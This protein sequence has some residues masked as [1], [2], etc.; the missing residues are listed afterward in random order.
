MQ[1][2]LLFLFR[3]VVDI[4][5]Q[6]YSKDNVFLLFNLNKFSI[7]SKLQHV[8]IEVIPTF[9]DVLK[10]GFLVTLYTGGVSV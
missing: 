3:I 7:R 9:V 8:V 10:L 1:S 4:V 2:Y 6:L 5:V